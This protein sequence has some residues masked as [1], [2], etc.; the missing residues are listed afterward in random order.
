MSPSARS[1]CSQS[2]SLKVFFRNYAP[3]SPGRLLVSSLPKVTNM[4]V[5][6][7]LLL[8]FLKPH[9]QSDMYKI[10]KCHTGLAQ[11][12]MSI[13]KILM[14][15]LSFS[16]KSQLSVLNGIQH[17]WFRVN[18]LKNL[19]TAPLCPRGWPFYMHNSYYLFNGLVS[20]PS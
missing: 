3:H 11:L 6:L 8:M 15:G 1:P 14:V 19:S 7:Y 4:K 17:V 9:H 20:Q 16:A 5:L 10:K 18:D 2:L 12:S 13:W